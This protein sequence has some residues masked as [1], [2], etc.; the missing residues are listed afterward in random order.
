MK[1][2]CGRAAAGVTGQALHDGDL[3]SGLQKMRG[4][5]MTQ[6]MQAAFSFDSRTLDRAAIKVQKQR[7]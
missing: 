5:G 3:H 6:R 7:L 2:P 1:I 4:E